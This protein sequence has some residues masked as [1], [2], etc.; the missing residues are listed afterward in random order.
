MTLF[1]LSKPQKEFLLEN[2]FNYKELKRRNSVPTHIMYFADKH[3]NVAGFLFL[4]KNMQGIQ[5]DITDMGMQ[6]SMLPVEKTNQMVAYMNSK[7]FTMIPDE[8]FKMVKD[9]IIMQSKW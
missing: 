1:N 8:T 3:I 9:L 4:A 7:S 5:Y 6:G 2:L